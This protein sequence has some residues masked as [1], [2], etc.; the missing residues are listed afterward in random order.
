MCQTCDQAK[1]LPVPEALRLIGSAMKRR[2][3]AA[4]LDQLV[5]KLVGEVMPERN[6]HAEAKFEKARR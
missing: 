2:G 4:C 3:A 1:T 6:A 5:G